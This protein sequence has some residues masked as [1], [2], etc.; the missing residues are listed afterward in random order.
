MCG[1]LFH[2]EP[3]YFIGAMYMSYVL[4]GLIGLPVALFLW[5]VGVDVGGMVLGAGVVLIPL[6]PWLFQYSRVLWLHF[7]HYFDPA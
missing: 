2:R 1:L 4:A 6:T 3:G 5:W 7:D